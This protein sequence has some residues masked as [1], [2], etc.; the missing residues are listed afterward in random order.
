MAKNFTVKPINLPNK[1][2]K[3]KMSSEKTNAKLD[4][5]YN[6]LP[7]EIIKPNSQGG[8]W[9][10]IILVAMLFSLITMMA[11]NYFINSIKTPT[12]QQKVVI[13]HQ[14]EVTVTVD[15]RLSQLE[16]NITPAIVNFYSQPDE[17][18]GPFYQD[19]YSYGSGFILTSDGWIVTSQSV[20]DKI[21]ENKYLILTSDYKIY[22]AEKTLTDSISPIVFVK[23]KAS[24]LPV[25]K[26]G[27][28]NNLISG[29]K[30]YGFIA[31]YPQIKLASLHL[32]DLKKTIL[33]DVVASTEQI[34]HF[35][36]V[37]EGY[38]NSLLGAPVVNLAGEIIAVV[39]D[40][41]TATPINLLTTVIKNLKQGKIIRPKFGVHYIDLAKYPRLN[42]KTRKF[43]NQ[44]ALLSGFKNLTA[45]EKNSAADKAGLKIGDIIT[46]IE[47]EPLNG[48]KTLTQ[49]IQEY[50]AGQTIKLVILRA[51][52]EISMEV[53]LE[54]IE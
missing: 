32:A 12:E 21:G 7:P 6:Q 2:A 4:K 24:N 9:L 50:E 44:G 54:E 33:P 29:Q 46:Q 26:L 37:R 27:D 53:K 8:K 20:L 41:K 17:T 14:E 43:L 13:E 11:Y 34:S 18:S 35:I 30:L 52:K 1:G 28:V 23:I 15:E 39:N 40:N 51:G 22:Q 5:I 3:E 45:V 36:S 42:L 47:N 10:L 38:D 16:K 49:I 31:S 48:S 19:N 25:A